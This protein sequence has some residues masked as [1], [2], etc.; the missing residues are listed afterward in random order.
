MTFWISS[1]SISSL[2]DPSKNICLI[3]F[4]FRQFLVVFFFYQS[5]NLSQSTAL[6]I[7]GELAGEGSV[8]V[9]VSLSD[10]C[11]M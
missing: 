2:N 1:Q 3:C 5:P 10:M 4:G 6:C 11:D 7:V 9:A 8:A